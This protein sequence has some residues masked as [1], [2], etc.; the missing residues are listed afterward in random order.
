MRATWSLGAGAMA[1]LVVAALGSL[2][3]GVGPK[4]A[5]LTVVAELLEPGPT[6]PACGGAHFIVVMHY[7]VVTVEAGA[8]TDPEIDV[9]VS[10][11]G[12]HRV[13]FAAGARHRLTLTTRRPWTTG[14]IVPN[15]KRPQPTT[16][17]WAL[18]VESADIPGSW[19][20]ALA[21]DGVVAFSDGSSLY[22]VFADGRFTL[23]PLG[24]SGRTVVGRWRSEDGR[25][26]VITGQ[27]G[28]VNGVSRDDDYRCMTL[29]LTLVPDGRPAPVEQGVKL[30]PVHLRVEKLVAITKAEYD[31][32][33]KHQ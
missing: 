5:P 17:Y 8:L 21:A 28:W 6:V 3:A 10:C 1:A 9:A 26:F 16:L 7:R 2:A 11:P 32:E 20:T 30:A 14:G 33:L 13:A 12:M 25:V 18:T 19:R 27:W 23:D 29:A 15:P 24:M 4:P 31:R 22:R